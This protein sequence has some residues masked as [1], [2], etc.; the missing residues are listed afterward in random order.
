M[1][2]LVVVHPLRTIEDRDVGD[3]L[4]HGWVPR[5]GLGLY[6][7]LDEWGEGVGHISTEERPNRDENLTRS[8]STATKQTQGTQHVQ[9]FKA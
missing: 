5:G 3:L 7:G 1:R 4:S 6:L 9:I 2:C 8:R